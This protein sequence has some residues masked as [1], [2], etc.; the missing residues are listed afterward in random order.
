MPPTMPQMFTVKAY[1]QGQTI[2][3]EGT[4]GSF[5]CIVNSGE[6]AVVKELNGEVV[7]LAKL[8]KGAVFGE[9]ALVGMDRRTASVVAL[10]YT[11]V[12]VVDRERL[13]KALEG[14]NPLVAALVRGLVERLATTSAKVRRETTPFDRL[15]SLA[16]LLQA[17]SEG[18]TPGEDG[19]AR[20]PLSRLVEYNQLTLRLSPAEV[21]Q[22]LNQLVSAKLAYL[23]RMAQ[24]RQLII[25]QPGQLARR[26][27]ALAERLARQAEAPAPAGPGG[28]SGPEVSLD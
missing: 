10:T 11:E 6:V 7:T 9:M 22:A 8:G 2:F 15:V 14:A 3:R 4:E 27:K 24:G 23:E 1:N 17:A 25:P 28:E 19:F 26:A 5:A 16:A 21:E 12:V 20:Y 18:L 13:Q